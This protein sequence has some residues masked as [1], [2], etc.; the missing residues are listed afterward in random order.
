MDISGDSQWVAAG[1]NESW[2]GIWSVDGSVLPNMMP[3]LG[4]EP[5]SHRRLSG[6]ADTVYSV[7]W[8]PSTTNDGVVGEEVAST[9]PRY[10]LS[11]SADRNVHLWFVETWSLVVVYQGHNDTVWDVEWGPYGHYFLSGGRDRAARLWSVDQI[12]YLRMFVG[13]DKDVDVVGFHANGAYVFTASVDKTVRMW[14]VKTGEQVR[15][16]RGHATAITTLECSR[17]GRSLASADGAGV[18][19][20]WDLATGKRIKQMRGHGKGGIWSVRWSIESSVILSAGMDGTVRLWDVSPTT[21]STVATM[22][23]AELDVGQG[24]G[25]LSPDPQPPTS[26]ADVSL[27]SSSSPSA[28]PAHTGRPV[29]SS[30]NPVI[31]LTTSVAAT[32]TAGTGAGASTATLAAGT[33]GSKR[34]G[35]EVVVTSDQ[36]AAFPT[37][38]TQLKTVKF[39]GANLIL[40]AGVHVP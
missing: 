1:S 5:S 21:G 9:K 34:K 22:P 25:D 28:G 23:P 15:V 32:A 36:I 20:L 17:D 6:H 3:R 8:S 7:A 18:I 4:E 11:A 30:N 40:A 31:T 12:G 24:L 29:S 26:T 16:F 19:I 38:R 39:T 35:K 27:L 14:S 33:G 13:H 37:R 2:I 10:L